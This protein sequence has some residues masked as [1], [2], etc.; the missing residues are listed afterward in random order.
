MKKEYISRLAKP[1]DAIQ[2]DGTNKSEII[3]FVGSKNVILFN[4]EHKLLILKSFR[5]KVVVEKGDFII[6]TLTPIIGRY[7]VVIRE[8][9]FRRAYIEV[10]KK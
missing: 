10:N 9:N 8:D 3:D 5:E 6:I 4:D 7:A 2:W 1:F